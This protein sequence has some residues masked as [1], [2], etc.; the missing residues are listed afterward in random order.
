VSD[1]PSKRRDAWDVVDLL[2]KIASGLVLLWFTVVVKQGAEDIAMAMRKGELVQRLIGDLTASPNAR[3]RQDLAIIALD[4][5]VGTDDSEMVAAIVE[6]LFELRPTTTEAELTNDTA[7]AVLK[8]RS[9]TRA[10]A[11]QERLVNA[12]SQTDRQAVVSAA[13]AAPT[14]LSESAPQPAAEAKAVATV[15]SNVLY[16]QFQGQLTRELINE[17]RGVYQ[18]DGIGTPAAERLAGQYKSSVRFFHDEDRVQAEA[19][20]DRATRFFTEKKCAL[21][22]DVEDIT[23]TRSRVPRGQLELWINHQC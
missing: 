11:L 22:V 18:K 17:L 12:V 16:I 8:R 13:S 23:A 4:G 1:Q 15:F 20:A 7:F 3:V 6:K 21:A 2:V 14:D 5:S 9:P 10:T 19:V